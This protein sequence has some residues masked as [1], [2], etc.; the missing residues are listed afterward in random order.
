VNDAEVFAPGVTPEDLDPYIGPGNPAAYISSVAYGRRFYILVESTESQTEIE[1]A[2]R[3][4][5]D[6]AA[7]GVDIDAEAR[8]VSELSE[9]RIKV[10]A[11]GG[12]QSLALATFNG[13]FNAVREFLTDGADFRT[14]VPL[15]YTL[16]ALKDKRNVSVKVATTYSVKDCVPVEDSIEDPIVWF[17]ASH[18]L[19][20]VLGTT[21]SQAK[22]VKSWT[23]KFP[24]AIQGTPTNAD[25]CGFYGDTWINDDEG[26]VFFEKSTSSVGTESGQLKYDGRGFEGGDYTIFFVGRPNQNPGITHFAWGAS[27][28]ANQYLALGWDGDTGEMFMTH[29]GGQ[30]LRAAMQL[31]AHS[32]A[33]YT[34]RFSRTEGMSIY[35]NDRLIGSDPS[36]TSP[37]NLYPEAQIGTADA[38]FQPQGLSVLMGQFKAYGSA[39]TEAQRRAQIINWI[40]RFNL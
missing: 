10:H 31:P 5:Y 12:D 18:G 17:D 9:V 2:I 7:A 40:N 22:F 29:G 30:T 13:D 26:A 37:L 14:G 1:A 38:D 6:A 16:R 35:E 39:V 21:A 4:S 32:W 11:Q 36:L 8:Y 23:S 20:I 27:R 25:L 3:A 19:D 28:T 24:S 34:F 15:V 33:V